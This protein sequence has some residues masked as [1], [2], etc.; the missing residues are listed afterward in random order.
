MNAG[1]QATTSVSRVP[2]AVLVSGSGTNLQAVIDACKQGQL[3]LDLRLVV[4]SKPDAY[5]LER[6][7]RA[8]IT[9]AVVRYDRRHET[10][11]QYAL[12]LAG[13]VRESGAELVLLLGWMHVLA[14]EFLDAGFAG[15]LNLHPAYLPEKPGDDVVVFAD[16]TTTPVFRGAHALR[17]ALAAN[18]PHTGASLIQI[19]GLVD[20]GPLL[21]RRSMQLH[22]QEDEAVALERLHAVEREVVREGILRWIAVRSRA[23]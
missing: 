7:R 22:P 9:A 13:V 12:R 1:T 20:R 2:T 16:G 19:T 15:V 4:S 14:Q 17:D 11:P 8:G 6:A 23:T 21:A 18:V 10:R 5:A 3:P